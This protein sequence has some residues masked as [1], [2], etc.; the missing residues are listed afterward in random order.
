VSAVETAQ[1]ELARLE[2]SR[3]MLLSKYTPDH[4][5]VQKIRR[6]IVRAEET[7]QRLKIAA[8]TRDRV[9]ASPNANVTSTRVPDRDSGDDVAIAQ[10]KSQLEA[11]RVEIDNLLKDENHLKVLIAQYEN[12]LNQIPIREQQQGGIVRETEALRQEYAELQKKE[13]ESQLA[14][15]LEKQQGGQQFRLIDPASFPVVPSSPKRFRI[16]L[17]GIAG[18]LALGL[19]LALLLELKDTS[20]HTDQ[21]L[22]KAF[23]P[24]FVVAVP[25]LSTPSEDRRSLW[26][27]IGRWIAGSALTL[28]VLVVEL[29]VYK[30][31]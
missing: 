3:A 27:G 29:Y 10:F 19:A 14:T 4:P 28:M 8:P 17:F 24:P 31:G 22:T 16:S 12:R 20:F 21:E 5:D 13:Q 9:A 7:L 11:N 30:R 2:D 25:L 18:G 26:I 23:N 15:N 6:E 1:N